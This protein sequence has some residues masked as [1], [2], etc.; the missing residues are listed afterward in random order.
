MEDG[1]KKPEVDDAVPET[2]ETEVMN[3][4]ERVMDEDTA[5]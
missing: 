5:A 1:R 2:G 3:V 4:D